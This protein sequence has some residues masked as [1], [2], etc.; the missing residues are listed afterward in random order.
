MA[1]T[2]TGDFVVGFRIGSSPWQKDLPPVCQF[3]KENGF[4][5]LDLGPESPENVRLVLDAGLKIGTVDL[6]RPWEAIASADE[7]KRQQAI[8]KTAAHVRAVAALGVNTFFTVV[9]PGD[10]SRERGE[11]LAIAAVGFRQ[12]CDAT[13]DC[14]ARFAIE[15]WPG[16]PPH[17]SSLVCTPE[18][19]RAFFAAVGSKSVGVNYDPSHLV[20]MDIDPVRFL[21]E[22]A[23]RIFHVHAKDTQILP[24]GL[25][26]FGN[27][28]PSIHAPPH[29]Y[30]GH[31]WRYTIPGNGHAR[32]P[33]LLRMLGR[34][35][36]GGPVSIELEDEEYNGSEAG[37]KRGL[38]ESKDFLSGA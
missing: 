10:P 1:R 25:Y 9:F 16:S 18:S 36:Y 2:K 24:E 19:Y 12:L 35:G 8:K 15:G 29:G 23:D 32:W 13:A 28:Q 4:E 26:Q 11:S 6:L 27:L 3:A 22:F 21:A 37:E 7:T 17:F 34:I 14:G 33:V 5:F 38:L 31:H 20:R 30:G